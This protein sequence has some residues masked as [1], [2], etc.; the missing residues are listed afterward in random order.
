MK[1]MKWIS[2]LLL[3][4][5]IGCTNQSVRTPSAKDYPYNPYQSYK[6]KATL[7]TASKLQNSG[8]EKA[9]TKLRAWAKAD[10]EDFLTVVMC[11]MLF[12][13][14]ETPLKRPSLGGAVFLGGTTYE[15]WPSEP[16]AL[17]EDIPILITKGY[18]L[19][20][21]GV[22]VGV[23]LEY[24]LKEGVWVSE[25]YERKTSDQIR[26]SVDNFIATVQWKQK[27][28]CSELEFLRSQAN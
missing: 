27:L 20:G 23:Y 24:C 16:I 1:K 2:T 8:R 17:F 6:I 21:E 15:H 19:G 18:V 7:D 3:L 5:V 11:R 14:K 26:A 10:S 28:S 9:I 12:K 25:N 13:G 22:P 4:Y